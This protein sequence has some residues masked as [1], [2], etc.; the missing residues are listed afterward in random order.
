MHDYTK[1][2]YVS[3]NVKPSDG[4]ANANVT[5]PVK[6]VFDGKTNEPKAVELL[7]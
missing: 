1:Q 3:W 4:Y 6:I 5:Y 2:G 7:K